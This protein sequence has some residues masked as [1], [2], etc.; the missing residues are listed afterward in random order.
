VKDYMRAAPL[1]EPRAARDYAGNLLA[2]VLSS[3]GH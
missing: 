1:M 2:G 3:A